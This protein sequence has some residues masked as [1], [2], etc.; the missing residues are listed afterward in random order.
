MNIH[1]PHKIST[2]IL[3]FLP[4]ILLSQFN[5]ELEWVVE[6]HTNTLGTNYFREVPKVIADG[7][8]GTYYIGSIYDPGPVGGIIMA[9]Y[10]EYGK[11]LWRDTLDDATV[12]RLADA[13]L[14][15][16]GN[17]IVGATMISPFG[18]GAA[19]YLIKYDQEGNRDWEYLV[20]EPSVF[21]ELNEIELDE[22][23]DIHLI[24]NRSDFGIDSIKMEITKISGADASVLWSSSYSVDSGRIIPLEARL[25]TDRLLVVASYNGFYL[26]HQV[27]LNGDEITTIENAYPP[28]TLFND[29]LHIDAEGNVYLG[30]NYGGYQTVKVEP[31]NGDTLWLYQ[32]ENSAVDGSRMVDFE[33]DDF[34]KIYAVG[35]VA[36]ENNESTLLTTTKFDQQGNILWQQEYNQS[37]DQFYYGVNKIIIDEEYLYVIGSFRNLD[38]IN[39]YLLLIYN[40]EGNLIHTE[41]YIHDGF[42]NGTA[43]SITK[44]SVNIFIAGSSYI[45]I[46]NVA[47]EK[48][49]HILKYRI[50]EMTNISDPVVDSFQFNVSPNP[51]IDVLMVTPPK[52][53]KSSQY[54]L[55]NS[56]GL[57]ENIEEN[58]GRIDLAKLSSGLY[59][60]EI[61]WEG[62]KE[63]HKVI[64][65]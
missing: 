30:M 43:R 32:K 60:L 51:T 33:E 12:D 3:L 28:G 55:Y 61:E 65:Q 59:L 62:G 23:N 63:T 35:V 53:V 20:V 10:D 57:Q 11:A 26:L 52:G 6:N 27:D 24:Q 56:T 9:H 4:T 49:Q 46:D 16:D 8:G 64:K 38:D 13:L 18:A 17:L 39:H 34:N 44:D 50:D 15:K 29:W 19:I 42:N 40:H 48:H 21:W 25:L 58:N 41:S 1:Y 37:G 31:T 54:R 45:A 47:A 36:D 5:L 22:N 7:M 2:L 14:D